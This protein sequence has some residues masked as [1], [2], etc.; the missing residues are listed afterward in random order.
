MSRR[1]TTQADLAHAAP[2]FAALGDGT[3]LALVDRLGTHGPQSIA[4]LTSGTDITRQAVTKHLYI[5][6]EAGFVHTSRRGRERIWELD[7][8]RLDEARS[9]LDQVAQQW[10]TVLDRLK[11]FVEDDPAQPADIQPQDSSPIPSTAVT[12]GVAGRISNLERGHGHD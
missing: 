1:S 7:T 5:L 9:Y 12:S 4:R 3:R 6:A 8:A 10:D 11:A 2:L